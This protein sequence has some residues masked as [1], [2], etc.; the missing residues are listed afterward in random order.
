LYGMYKKIGVRFDRNHSKIL[1]EKI[2]NAG[3]HRQTWE[4][5]R[6]KEKLRIQDGIAMKGTQRFSWREGVCRP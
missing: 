1:E 6:V 4:K 2:K 5:I 3:K